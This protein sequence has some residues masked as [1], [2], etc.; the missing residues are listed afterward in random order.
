MDFV[1]VDDQGKV[2]YNEEELKNKKLSEEQINKIK[3][4]I[5]NEILK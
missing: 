2:S 5:L 4:R 3:K 1:N